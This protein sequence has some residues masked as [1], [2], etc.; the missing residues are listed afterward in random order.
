MTHGIPA[1]TCCQKSTTDILDFFNDF[2]DLMQPIDGARPRSAVKR[3]RHGALH[4]PVQQ[5]PGGSRDPG[6]S[7]DP[8]GSRDPMTDGMRRLKDC[9]V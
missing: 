3:L 5:D 1:F 9:P 2:A 7:R 6:E 4:H 8:G